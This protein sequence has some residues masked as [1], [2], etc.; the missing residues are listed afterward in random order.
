MNERYI[1]TFPERENHLSESIDFYKLTMGQIALEKFKNTEVTFTFKNRNIERPL[2]EFVTVEALTNR[3]DKIR[4]QGFK[5]EEIAY[6]AG[7]QAQDGSARFDEPY[8]NYLADIKLPE[9]SVKIDKNTGELDINSCGEWA[10]V[11]LWET[12]I[13]SEANEEYYVRKLEAE[14]ININELF[15]YGDEK[16]SEKISII[17]NRPDIKIVDFGT[18]RRFSAK[19]QEHVIKRL[20]NEAPNNFIGTS[21]PWFAYKFNTKAIGTYAHEMP[22]VYAALEDEKGKNPLDGH[23]KMLNDWYARYG[24][25]LSIALTDTFTSDFFFDDITPEQAKEWKGLRHDSSD[26]FKFGEQVIS[27]YEKLDIDPKTKTLIFSDGLDIDMIIKLADYF[28]GRINVVYGWGTTLMND[29][30]IKANN[31]V[32]KATKA[33]QIDTVKLSDNVGKNTGP[34]EQVNRYIINK[35]IRLFGAATAQEMIEL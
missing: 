28:K 2:S 27:F 12:V 35:N 19:W 21:N 10:A 25:D 11:S 17:K 22:M 26:P 34:E 30:G 9:V 16:L 8:L 23:A 15:A 18:R 29:M 3:L 7:I 20:I 13:M 14:Q 4:E 32:M 6:F 24:E 1:Q 5:A 31:I 33:N